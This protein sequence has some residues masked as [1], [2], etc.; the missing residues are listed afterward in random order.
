MVGKQGLAR[1]AV[2]VRLKW[3]CSANCG[4]LIRRWTKTRWRGRQ[5]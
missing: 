3:S 2:A 4:D 1:W 5:R